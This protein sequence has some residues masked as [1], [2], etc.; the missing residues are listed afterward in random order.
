MVRD[1]NTKNLTEA[2]EIKKRWQE[3]KE[4]LHKEDL[5]NLGYH[6]GVVSHLGT[7]ILK[8][9][10]KWAF[11]SVQSV[12]SYSATP[13]TAARQVFLSVANSQSLL[14]LMSIESVM[15][16]NPFILCRPLLLPPSIVPSIWVFLSESVVHIR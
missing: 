10:V 16:F 9:E 3:H 7:D 5:N 4:E 6:D 12:V 2:D 13:W 1:R 8:C 14:K 11:S 15:P